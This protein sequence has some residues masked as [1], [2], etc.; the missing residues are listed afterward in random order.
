MQIS[1]VNRYAGKRVTAPARNISASAVSGS[2][3]KSQ[4]V[5][6]MLQQNSQN[7]KVEVEVDLP[8]IHDE[9]GNCLKDLLYVS[10]AMRTEDISQEMRGDVLVIKKHVGE[11]VQ[12]RYAPESTDDDPIAHIWG[13]HPLLGE[14]DYCVHLNDLDLHDC[15][16]VE[17]AAL[18]EHKKRTGQVK[19][20]GLLESWYPLPPQAVERVKPSEYG[21]FG[22]HNWIQILRDTADDYRI[23]GALGKEIVQSCEYL[24]NLYEGFSHKQEDKQID[25]LL[26]H[27]GRSRIQYNR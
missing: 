3:T 19:L 13:R 21:R 20:H 6:D 26:D 23:C 10:N 11:Y 8:P 1:Q 5:G 24:A 22:H 2:E 27:L 16:G 12:A 4:N 18:A 7:V 9:N 15:N 17:F 14:V 25:F